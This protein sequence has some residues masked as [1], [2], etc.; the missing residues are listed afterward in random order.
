MISKRLFSAA[1][2]SWFV[3]FVALALLAGTTRAQTNRTYSL[4]AMDI[5]QMEQGWG[6]PHANESVE[7][8]PLSIGGQTFTNGIGTHAASRFILDLGGRAIGFSAM[9]GIDDEVGN[10]KG[11]VKFKV[12]GDT[13]QVLWESQELHGGDAPVAVNVDLAGVNQI[14]LVVD[15]GDSIDFDHADWADASL[16]M[17]RGR[18]SVGSAIKEDAIILT[19][20]SSPQPRINSARVF[21]VRPGA[22]FLFT[23]A[24]TGDRPMTFTAKGL[25]RGLKLDKNTGQIT[26]NL[27]NKGES[28]VTLRAKNKLGT[29]EQKFKIVCGPQIGLVPA[30]GWNSWN[31]FASAVTE[32]KVKSAADAMVKSGLINHGWTYINIDDYW[33]VHRNSK[34]PTLQGPQRDAA[35]HILPNPRF[36]DMKGLTD[37][38]HAKGLKAGLY[39]SPGPWTCG[40]CV[41]SWQHEDLDAQ[42]YGQW[43]FDYLKYDWCSYGDIVHGDRSLPTLQKPY[44]VMRAALDKVNRD[45]LFSFCQYGDGNVWEWGAEI[46]GNSWRTT[47][48]IRDTWGSMSRIGFGQAGH[49]KY[50]GPGHFN[51]PDMLVVG[52]VG[53]G[54]SLHPTHLSPNEQYTH[55]SLWCLLAAPLLIGCDMTQM[56]DFT[57]NLLSNDEMLEVDQDPLGRQA[58]RVAQNSQLEV[59]A[60][61][62]EDGSKAVGLFNRGYGEAPVNVNWSD[63]GLTGKQKVRD[64]WRQKD[65][66]EFTGSFS[67]SVPRHGV[68]LVRIWPVK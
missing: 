56:D 55:I 29:A 16:V 20:Q 38:I 30:L 31:C 37:Y 18:P 64:L 11:H 43:G 62:M 57:F 50:A 4:S 21:G 63:L 39:S 12:L 35:G 44:Q 40:G 2:G 48:D 59:W 58:A 65:L 27:K 26:G 45:I 25:P 6:E 1:S 61:D 60:K 19:P 53:W 47:G 52:K 24:A 17:S 8:H 36:P 42:S 5:S 54:P 3:S 14:T 9:V 28:L 7:G 13:N 22:P 23:I 67:A 32:E 46:G 41:A 34:D 10:G 66:G 68:V 49:E 15:G 33:E 51:D